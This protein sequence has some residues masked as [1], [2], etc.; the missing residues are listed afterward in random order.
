M[1]SS[2]QTVAN[3]P[4]YQL[5]TYF[6]QLAI[7]KCVLLQVTWFLCNVLQLLNCGCE[8]T[9]RFHHNAN[10]WTQMQN[11]RIRAPIS[12]IQE[13]KRKRFSSQSHR[14]SIPT[15]VKVITDQWVSETW[16]ERRAFFFFFV[17][18]FKSWMQM[19]PSQITSE[20]KTLHRRIS[21]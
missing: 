12:A 4:K 15:T 2:V 21:L 14:V 3:H 18:S 8:L 11:L 10:R 13:K 19:N 17:T 16:C 5:L 1:P 6:P 20:R 9:L 7:W